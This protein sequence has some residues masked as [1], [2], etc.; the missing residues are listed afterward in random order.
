M[1]LR[2]RAYESRAL[3]TELRRQKANCFAFC[4]WRY[5]QVKHSDNAKPKAEPSLSALAML[6]EAESNGRLKV[7]LYHY[8]F[9]YS[10]SWRICGLDYTISFLKMN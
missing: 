2:P 9:R 1:R 4:R 8:S 7:M 3:L 10:A 5:H 6:R